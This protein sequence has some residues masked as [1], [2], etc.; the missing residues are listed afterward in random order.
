MIYKA[1]LFLFTKIDRSM[2]DLN[3]YVYLCL[4]VF[5]QKSLDQGAPGIHSL[6]EQQIGR[7]Q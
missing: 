6:F 4:R 3:R 7:S 1:Y 5:G 2:A